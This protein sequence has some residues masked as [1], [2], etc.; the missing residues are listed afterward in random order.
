MERQGRALLTSPSPPA[1]FTVIASEG[2]DG[3][4]ESVEVVRLRLP[5]RPAFV[6]IAWFHLRSRRLIKRHAGRTDVV[7]TCGAITG[8]HADVATVH[9]CHAAVPASS[10]GRR[11][12]W[13]RANAGLARRLGRRYERRQYRP[14]RTGLLVAVS[15]TVERELA[16]YYAGVPRTVIV[17]GVDVTP[18]DTDVDRD[19]GGDRALRAVMVT[20]DFAVKGVDVAIEAL[21]L[22]RTVEL[23][24]VGGG[25]PARYLEMA[26]RLG[27]EDRVTF[28]G[29]LDDVA[30]IYRR[31]DVVVCASVY[32]SFGL[33]LVEAAL[34][35]CAVV[36]N[37][38]GVAS[39]LV[40]GGDGGI[41]VRRSP[42]ELADALSSLAGD[43]ER[44]RKLGAAARQRALRYD[45]R[46]MVARYGRLYRE[47]VSAR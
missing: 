15:P 22:A 42:A 1:Q 11:A 32:E 30:P 14:E 26:R 43:R 8:A 29:H 41:I 28:T 46:E 16:E 39:D 6:R 18:L 4:P 38:V 47:L 44:V 12:R 7:H 45:A 37:D 21:A 27:V 20:G 5:R 31:S 23:T 36:S 35:G 3:L 9:L 13:R 2:L 19:S 24:I 33:S 10:T 17:N 25:D 40:D 34:A